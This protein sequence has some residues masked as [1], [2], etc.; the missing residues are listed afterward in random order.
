[1]THLAHKDVFMRYRG[2]TGVAWKSH[3]V[4]LSPTQSPSLRLY[5]F[6][7]PSALVRVRQGTLAPC[8]PAHGVAV[9]AQPWERTN[10][11][12]KKLLKL[13]LDK[14]YFPLLSRQ[15]LG[16]AEQSMH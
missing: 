10:E 15:R 8:A 12:N 2:M 4:Y 7:H 11:N 13:R 14:L 3:V 5:P 6:F 9:C 16:G 1:M